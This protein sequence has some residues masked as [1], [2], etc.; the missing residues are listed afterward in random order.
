VALCTGRAVIPITHRR[1]SAQHIY[2]WTTQIPVSES[3]RAYPGIELLH[4]G[5]VLFGTPFY[6]LLDL[7]LLSSRPV[8]VAHTARTP[9]GQRDLMVRNHMHVMHVQSYDGVLSICMDWIV[10]NPIFWSSFRINSIR[11]NPTIPDHLFG[12]DIGS[13]EIISNWVDLTLHGRFPL[14]CPRTE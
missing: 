9:A 7:L 1:P 3:K 5:R 8:F 11:G 10:L 13:I 2:S 6:I 4:S 14:S 12:I